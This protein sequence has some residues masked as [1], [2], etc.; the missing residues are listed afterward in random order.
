MVKQ[1]LVTP[2]HPFHTHEYLFLLTKSA[3]Y[4]Y[5]PEPIRDPPRPW[6]G[7]EFRP[8]APERKEPDPD[9]RYGEKQRGHSRRHTGFNGRWDRMS[10]A[11]QQANGANKRYV[12]TV[13]TQTYKGHF[14]VYPEKLVEPCI[15]AGT[16]E[17]GVCDQCGTPW[18]TLDWFPTCDHDSEL[19]PAVVL[20]P[21]CGSGTTGVVALRHGRSFVG[22]E[23]NPE[24]VELSRKRIIED[25]PLLNW[26]G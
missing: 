3:T 12:W 10:K 9:I 16:S 26:Q 25:A 8:R 5:D 19:A 14:A 21:F 6:H 15:L 23:L 20:D 1:T 4:F 13:A 18:S 17:H 7:D 24:Y 2:P 22:I 11:E